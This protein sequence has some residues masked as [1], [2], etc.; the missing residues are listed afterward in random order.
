MKSLSFSRS[1]I[2]LD[3]LTLFF[4]KD[5]GKPFYIYFKL[6]I[7]PKASNF[8][9]FVFALKS[10]KT[11]L[12]RAKVTMAVIISAVGGAYKSPFTPNKFA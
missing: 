6:M 5:L 10:S 9:L 1:F 2:S 11:F 12:A 8:Y 4:K 7:Y 3:Q